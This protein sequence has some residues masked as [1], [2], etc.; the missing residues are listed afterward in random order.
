MENNIEIILNYQVF[1]NSIAGYL[2]SILIFIIIFLIISLIKLLV[3]K[4]FSRFVLK[5]SSGFDDLFVNIINSF[6]WPF[7]FIISLNV[8][9]L[10]LNL[11]DT[12]RTIISSIT[13]FL[14]IFYSIKFVQQVI[15]YIANSFIKKAQ[16]ADNSAQE[17]LINVSKKFIMIIIWITAFLLLLQNLGLDISAIVASFGV[18]GIILAFAVQS[19]LEDIFASV[20]IYFDRPF[21]I[22]DF[23]AIGDHRGTVTKIGLKS[24]R[25]KTLDGEELVVS[26]KELTSIRIRNFKNLKRRRILLQINVTYSTPYEKL[27]K[28]PE[29]IK[30]IIEKNKNVEFS[31]AHFKDLGE[32]A[33]G[34]D[35][36]YF[37]NTENY[38][39]YLDIRQKINFDLIKI[40][41]KESI[42]FAF[43]TQQIIIENK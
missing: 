12:F 38:I 14:A 42:E 2:Y 32:Y 23:I 6:K 10:F 41:E 29:L 22:G 16:A 3:V 11:S 5:T 7:V 18:S 37:V 9:I 40:F 27:Q 43:P 36:V 28:I 17:A 33:L 15:D 8:S 4:H 26:N 1:S 30:K 19:I 21:E 13:L 24:S 34:Y 35:I 31:R 25:L 39:E 20:S